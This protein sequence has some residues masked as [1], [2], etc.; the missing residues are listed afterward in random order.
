MAVVSYDSS[1]MDNVVSGFNELSRE[2]NSIS[3][4]MMTAVARIQNNWK[5]DDAENA[6]TDLKAINSQMSNIQ[7]N[8]DEVINALNQVISNFGQLKY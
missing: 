8:I 6:Q 5:G 7:T 1:K 2:I 4:D 3:H